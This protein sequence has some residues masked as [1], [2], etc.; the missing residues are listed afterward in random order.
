MQVFE[1]LTSEPEPD[2]S[3][4]ADTQRAAAPSAP[5]KHSQ[6][7]NP[8]T[9]SPRAPG[10]QASSAEF[11]V[12]AA[13]STRPSPASRLLCSFGPQLSYSPDVPPPRAAPAGPQGPS[14]GRLTAKQRLLCTPDVERTRRA[15][16]LPCEE[17][18]A[19]RVTNAICAFASFAA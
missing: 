16:F 4:L 9:A 18:A 14:H 15:V 17:Q 5:E 13:E 1:G 8:P 2:Q 19:G 3:V 10:T 7:Q 12:E 6:P 11:P